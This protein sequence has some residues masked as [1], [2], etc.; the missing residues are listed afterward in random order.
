MK[1][2]KA[3]SIFDVRDGFVLVGFCFLFAGISFFS[4]PVAL[5]V[6]GAIITAKGLFKWV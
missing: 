3:K 6:I 5:I 1:T 2:D 4:V